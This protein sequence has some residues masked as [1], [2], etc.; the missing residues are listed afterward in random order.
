MIFA[1]IA[2]DVTGG[3]ELAAVLTG[4]GVD[5]GFVTNPEKV[6]GEPSAVVIALK[7]RTAPPEEAV[8]AFASALRA[9]R[10]VEA[11]QIFFKY[12]A[13]FDST[14]RG[15]IG[16]C[17]ELLADHA[18]ADL[19]L[20]IPSFPEAGRYVFQGHLFVHD[21]LVSESPKRHDPIT[22]M[23]D[24]DLVRVLQAQTKEKVG[25][26]P[27][28]VLSEGA[29]SASD[30]LED[31]RAAGVRFVIADAVSD[32]DLARL[33]EITAHWPL[34]TG[35]STVAGFYPPI[36]RRERL[37]PA[38]RASFELP[39]IDGPA[40]V[41]AGSCAERTLEQLA[42][43]GQHHPVIWIDPFETVRTDAVPALMQKALPLLAQGPVALASSAPPEK[44]R[45][46]Q[47]ALG[48]AAA[49]RL[50]EGVIGRL[51]L[52][53]RKAGARRFLIAGGETS[54]AVLAHLGIESLRVGRYESAGVGRAVTEDN[55]PI[56]LCLKS[57]KLGPADMF[58]PVLD[59]MRIG[60]A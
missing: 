45:T 57:G 17:S 27:L 46:V 4:Q 35:N 25:L 31:L 40:V 11:K 41:L 59:K 54:G 1:A 37:L 49:G 55:E 24:P 47:E 9:L 7:T 16:P 12:C 15:N 52:E 5:C 13:T 50:L 23:T 2:D 58:L 21:R 42:V 22:P 53:L 48:V 30:R 14:R 44:V 26:L 51:A 10:R 38:D 34:T 3:M 6:T 28:Q 8:A 29:K 60:G 18:G 33:A 32:A 19:A 20:F 43:F 36:W 56:A 39:P